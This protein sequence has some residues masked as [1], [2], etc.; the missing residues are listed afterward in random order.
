[1]SC[2]HPLTV[3]RSFDRFTQK[4]SAK[5]VPGVRFEDLDAL[6]NT[7]ENRG[8]FTTYMHVPCGH[9]VGCLADRSL[10][11]VARCSLEQ[12]MSNYTYFVTA[13]FDDDHLPVKEVFNGR[14]LVPTP[15]LD[16]R[17]HQLF[18][19]RFRRRFEYE[20]KPSPRYFMCG[21]YG[22]RTRRPHFHYLFFMSDPLPDLRPPTLIETG[23]KRPPPDVMT[24][25]FLRNAW[26]NGHISVSPVN[27]A[28]IAYVC[29]Y[30]LKKLNALDE[31]AM[32]D[33]ARLCRARQ[34]VDQATGEVVGDLDDYVLPP[35]FISYS[36]SIG[37]SYADGR[38]FDLAVAGSVPVLVGDKV[39]T[40]PLPSSVVRRIERQIGENALDVPQSIKNHLKFKQQRELEGTDLPHYRY[41]EVK[42]SAFLDKLKRFPERP[43]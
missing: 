40:R 24:C 36:Q 27:P 39:L 13:T 28:R 11:W 32:A 22:D 38:E 14:E 25:D 3:K 16:K 26:S 17:E 9:C 20:E 1:M 7:P 5:I 4:Y 30:T 31:R 37:G 18:L 34:L 29:R 41:L 15:V 2:F 19:K 12:R 35:E 23:G 8:T 42:E 33:Q 43:I 6:N 10:Q 21:E